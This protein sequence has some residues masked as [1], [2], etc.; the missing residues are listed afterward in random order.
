MT[1]TEAFDIIYRLLALMGV[2]APLAM[3]A[4]M[5]DV[6]RT[7]KKVIRTKIKKRGRT[8]QGKRAK[9]DLVKLVVQ[10]PAIAKTTAPNYTQA[11]ILAYDEYVRKRDFKP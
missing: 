7:K 5:R 3:C 8:G 6:R 4:G 9:K 11:D 1:I 10:K 2:F